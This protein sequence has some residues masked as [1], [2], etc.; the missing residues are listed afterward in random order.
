MNFYLTM[1][2][3]VCPVADSG[4]FIIQQGYRSSTYHWLWDC[5]EGD[6]DYWNEDWVYVGF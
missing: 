2:G 6:W 1:N 5:L 3:Q 4:F